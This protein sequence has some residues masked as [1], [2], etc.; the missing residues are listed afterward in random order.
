MAARAP[1]SR[2]KHWHA[3]RACLIRHGIGG[4]VTSHYGFE[5]VLSDRIFFLLFT[6]LSENLL[7]AMFFHF[8]LI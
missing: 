8:H 6:A 5:T 1:V 7:V 4:K 2:L 3:R